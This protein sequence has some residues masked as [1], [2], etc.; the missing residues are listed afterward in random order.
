MGL[1]TF[2][3]HYQ[4]IHLFGISDVRYVNYRVALVGETSIRFLSNLTHE[5]I[6]AYPE[7]S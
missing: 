7:L 4:S 1:H 6:V 2:I 5:S 3:G